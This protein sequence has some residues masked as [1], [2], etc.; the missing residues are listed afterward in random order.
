MKKIKILYPLIFLFLIG[1]CAAIQDVNITVKNTKGLCLYQSPNC[2]YCDNETMILD[3]T[4]DYILHLT[5]QK[6]YGNCDNFSMDYNETMSEYVYSGSHIYDYVRA[7]L[8]FA[9]FLGGV[10]YVKRGRT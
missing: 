1:S 8:F 10:L 6:P 7:G 5:T 4:S 2:Q 9:V 3:G